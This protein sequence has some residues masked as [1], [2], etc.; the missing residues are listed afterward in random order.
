MGAFKIG[1]FNSLSY[2]SYLLELQADSF[3]NT[4]FRPLIYRCARPVS[5]GLAALREWAPQKLV[6]ASS[7]QVEQDRPVKREYH[8]F[9]LVL[10]S[11]VSLSFFAVLA[12]SV[13]ETIASSTNGINAA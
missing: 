8:S 10:L 6:G 2:T 12:G 9:F 11:L 13:F 1:R 4:Y 5:L 3:P 7:P